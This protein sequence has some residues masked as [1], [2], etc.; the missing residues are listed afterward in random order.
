M[1]QEGE[2]LVIQTYPTSRKLKV[3]KRTF[4]YQEARSDCELE[5]LAHDYSHYS[6]RMYHE[7]KLWD[8]NSDG[9]PDELSEEQFWEI[10]PD[11]EQAAQDDH[12]VG[13]IEVHHCSYPYYTVPM[14]RT[15]R[16]GEAVEYTGAITCLKDDYGRI[17]RECPNCAGMLVSWDEECEEEEETSSVPTA[18]QGCKNYHGRYYGGTVLICGIH[19]YGWNGDNCPDYRT[20]FTKEPTEIS[21]SSAIVPQCQSQNERSS[22]P[23]LLTTDLTFVTIRTEPSEK[24]IPRKDDEILESSQTVPGNVIKERLRQHH[25]QMRRLR[26]FTRIDSTLSAIAGLCLLGVGISAAATITAYGM[27][28]MAEGGVKSLQGVK[29]NNTVKVTTGFGLVAG[30]GALLCGVLA[31]ASS[32][33]DQRTRP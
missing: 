4:N 33:I 30:G 14:I 12:A 11:Y 9:T 7:G 13:D 3:I 16:C 28:L 21:V 17:V 5:N 26:F 25:T 23:V 22:E 20:N 15:N 8:L 1:F 29:W 2:Y 27:G 32:V 6:L 10:H 18:C 24:V 19:P 31:A